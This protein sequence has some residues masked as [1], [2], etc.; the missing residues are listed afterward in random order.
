MYIRTESDVPRKGNVDR[1]LENG[2]R[3]AASQDV[4]RKG[5]VDRNSSPKTN[6]YSRD[7][8]VPRKGNVDRNAE[9]AE[10]AKSGVMTFPARG[11]WIEIKVKNRKG[12]T[13]K[14]R[15]PCGERG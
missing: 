11:T 9:P 8:D 6:P 10:D 1:N 13:R 4:P 15:S 7:P 5:N 2:I 14:R 3:D 12:A